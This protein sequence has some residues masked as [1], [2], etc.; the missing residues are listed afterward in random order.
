MNITP[1]IILTKDNPEYLYVTLKS[2]T[3][4]STKRNPVI[5]LDNCSTLDITKKFLYSEEEIT[6][7]I[8]DWTKRENMS[9]QEQADKEYADD[10]LNIPKIN[11]IIGIKKKFS[12]VKTPKYLNQNQL[13]IYAINLAFT[14]FPNS[15]NC[16]IL[17]DNII[18]NK[19]WL[20]EAL[21]IF[22][23]EKKISNIGII[24]TFSEN[25]RES[26]YFEYQK[27]NTLKGKMML[28]TI[29]FYNELK[30]LLTYNIPYNEPYYVYI[31]S[32][33]YKLGFVTF[34]SGISYIQSLEP[35][36]LSTKDKLFKFDTSFKKPLAWN[37]K[38]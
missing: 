2:L 23:E 30:K 28:I 27:N 13:V 10:F 22:E 20:D 8:S 18:F 26:E 35:R 14:L 25:V 24:S 34:T 21:R 19:N 1:I 5:I 17:D 11:Q 29:N 15:N 4:T 3:A 33:A 31:Q 32:L 9:S 16:C 37:E 6:S 36:H 38:F 12:V 7:S